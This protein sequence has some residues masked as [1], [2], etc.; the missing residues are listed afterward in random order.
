MY[1]R[2]GTLAVVTVLGVAAAGCGSSDDSEETTGSTAAAVS[3]LSAE[4]QSELKA[5]IATHL[6]RPTSVGITQPVTAIPKDKTL[7]YVY[8]NTPVA[9]DTA[10]SAEKAAT[11]L[12]W[13]FKSSAVK[14]TP[15]GFQKGFDDALRDKDTDAIISTAVPS[16]VVA[17]RVQQAA[18]RDIPVA[19]LSADRAS[20]DNFLAIGGPTAYE[21][22]GKIQ[23]DYILSQSKGEANVLIA[24][25]GAL[26]TLNLTKDAFL[27]EWKAKCP[28][29]KKPAVYD[30][31]VTSLGTTFPA[32][33]TAYLQAHRNIDWV[34][35]GFNDMVIGVP[36]A[37]KAAGLNNIKATTLAQGAQS[38]PQLGGGFL[39]AEV[40]VPVL[41]Y[42]W[43]AI[44]GVIRYLNKESLAPNQA[45]LASADDP[46]HWIITK[47]G[48]EAA[49]LDPKESWP[50]N[51][52][53]EAEFTRL[54]GLTK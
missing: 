10:K 38:N 26:P 43:V 13:K 23:A 54:W 4:V 21:G 1:K 44:D 49:G 37:L 51:P 20:G 19:V 50:L 12:G 11:A 31:P 32:L 8:S 22:N 39:E 16:Q 36:G 25:P 34:V 2:I 17:S 41:E 48:M 6:K 33:L 28:T 3:K 42:P 45:F 29:C 46:T 47:D 53:F 52:N 18:K 40:G 9:A 24:V 30:A 15:E 35:L 14:A 7:F 27:A 5:T